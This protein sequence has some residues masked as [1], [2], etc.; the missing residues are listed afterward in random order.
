MKKIMKLGIPILIFV[1]VFP[2]FNGLITVRA[3]PAEEDWGVG[4]SDV[5]YY[6]MGLDGSLT[7]PGAIWDQLTDSMWEGLN[8]DFNNSYE[9]GYGQAYPVGYEVGYARSAYN[10]PNQ[11]YSDDLT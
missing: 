7:L 1:L 11:G 9:Y 6:T 10:N 5:K 4:V 2:M 8:D 3:T